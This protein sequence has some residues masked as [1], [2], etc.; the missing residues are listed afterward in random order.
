MKQSYRLCML[1]LLSLVITGC[2]TT[3]GT[4]GSGKYQSPLN[5]FTVALPNWTN[6]KIRDQNDDNSGSV[7]FH[8]DLG[9]LSAITYSRLP[10]DAATTFKDDEK[11]YAAYRDYFNNVAAPAFSS[12]A[13]KGMRTVREELLDDGKNKVYFAL[14]DLPEGS[15]LADPK[16]NRRFDAM[17]GL[18][19]FDRNGFIYMVEHEMSSVFGRVDPS[20]LTAQQLGALQETLKRL[21]DSMTFK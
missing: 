10:A 20:T 7:S 3:K 9:S 5:N 21:K 12:R 14:I 11:R 6:L 13:A 4:V 18:L 19:I 2:A 16:K 17:K 15:V 1:L 8:D